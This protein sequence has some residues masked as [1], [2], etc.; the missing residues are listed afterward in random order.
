MASREFIESRAEMEALLRQGSMGHLGL[1]V[2]GQ[3]YV[4]PLNYAYVDGRI[5]FHCALSGAKLDHIRANERVCFTVARQTGRVHQ[6]AGQDPCQVDSDS[7]ICIGTAHLIENLEARQAALNAFNRRFHPDG[8]DI[9]TERTR[10]CMAVEIR[11][12]EMT[13]RREREA[14]VTYWRWRF[15]H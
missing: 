12:V 7:V 5:L 13:G 2:K 14:G 11:I 15:Q 1:S 9:G 10:N 8:T 4:V 6:H 3:P